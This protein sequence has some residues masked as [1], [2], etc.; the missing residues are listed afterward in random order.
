MEN[1]K[2]TNRE[3]DKVSLQKGKKYMWKYIQ[4]KAKVGEE[5]RGAASYL[6]RLKSLFMFANKFAFGSALAAIIILAL[7][8]TTNFQGLVINKPQTV[9]ASFEMSA[10]DQDASGVSNDSSFTLKST[11]DYSEEVIA[12]NLKV[13]PEVEVKIEKT[14]SGEYEIKP[15]NPLKENGVYHFTITSKQ[16]DPKT[17]ET[18][19]VEFSWTYQVQDNFKITGTL[20]G[21][22]STGVPLETGIEFYFSHENFDFDDAKKHLEISPNVKGEFHKNNKT[23]VFVPKDPLNEATIYNV[24]LKKG[25]KLLDSDKVLTEDLSFAFETIKSGET[26]RSGLQFAQ[27]DYEIGTDSAVAMQAYVYDLESQGID[28]VD[29]EIFKYS[30]QEDF[31]K[32]LQKRLEIPGWCYYSKEFFVHDTSKLKSLGTFKATVEETNY[33]GYIYL[34]DLNLESGYYLFQAKSKDLKVPPDQALV[35]VTDVSAYINISSTDSLIWVNDVKTDQPIENAKVEIAGLKGDY[36]TNKEGILTFKTP[37]NWKNKFDDRNSSFIKIN[38]NDGRAL[39]T[40]V[41]PY[42]DDYMAKYNYWMSFSTD[43][44][45]YK[46]TDKIKFFGFIK[47]KTGKDEFKDLKIKMEYGYQNYVDEISVDPK[48]DGTFIGEIALKNYKPGYYNLTMTNGDDLITSS[49][50]EIADY[51]KPAYNLTIESDKKAVFA[52]ENVKLKVTSKFFDG[53]ALPNLKINYRTSDKEEVLYTDKSGEINLNEKAQGN[54]CNFDNIDEYYCYDINNRYFEV[55]SV[56]GEE[57]DIWDSVDIRIFNSRLTLTGNSEVDEGF[58]K[59]K[60]M[61]N[62][63]DL[64][65]LNSGEDANYYDFIGEVAKGKTISGKI[66]ES[67]WIKTESGQY[68]D[69]INK[70]TQKT[71][72]YTEQKKVI[73]EFK[74]TTDSKGEASYKF[75]VKVDRSYRVLLEAADEKGNMAHEVT[76]FYGSESRSSDYNYY[77]MKILNDK[78]KSGSS[79]FEFGDKVETAFANND[80]VLSS[81]KNGKFLFMQLSNGLKEYSVSNSPNYNFEFKKE[82]VPN[83]NISGVWFNGNSYEVAYG[84][85]A[86]YKNELER[87]KVEIK[88]D[89]ESYEPGEKVT[90]EVKVEDQNGSPSKA[91]VN[92]NLVDEAYY[93][94][95]YDNFADPLDEIYADN[96][97]GVLSQY[98][99]HQNPISGTSDGGK[100]GCFTADTKILMADGSYKAIKDIKIGDMILTKSHAYSLELVPAEVTNTISHEVSEYLVINEDLEV[101]AEH[102]VFVN[103]KWDLAGNVKIGDSLQNKDGVEIKVSSIRQVFEP[104]TVYNFEVKEKHTYFANN[105]YVHNDKGGDGVRN[106]F[107]DTAYFDVVEVGPSGFGEVSFKLPDNITSWRVTSKAIDGADL[108]AGYGTGSI[109]VSLD[110]FADIV[111]NNEYSV[112]DKP[113]LKMRTFGESLK[114]DA[115]VEFNVSA[116]SLG[117]EKGETVYAKGFENAYFALPKLAL[118]A[119]EVVVKVSASGKEDALSKIITVKGSRLNKDHVELIRKVDEKTIFELAEDG[120]T[121]IRFMDGGSAY[122]Y[123]NLLNLYYTDGDRLDQRLSQIVAAEL[124]K[125]HFGED[126]FTYFEDIV[127]NYQPGGLKLLPYGEADIKLTAMVLAVENNPAR[128]DQVSLKQYLYDVYQNKESNLDEIVLSLLGLASLDEPILLSLRKI[129]DEPKLTVE[130]KLY[131]A[132][133]FNNL[134][135]KAEAKKIYKEV[136]DKLAT[137]EGSVYATAVGAVVASGVGEIEQADLLWEFVQLTGFNNE[138]SNLYEIGYT[139]NALAHSNPEKLKFKVKVNEHSEDVELDKWETYG[140]MAYT[141]DLVATSV[142]AGDLAAVVY[143]SETV[144]P[145][146]FE[147]DDRLTIKRYY[148]VDG[149]LVESFKEGDLVEVLLTPSFSGKIK[150]PFFE[151]TDVLP[152][153]FV[154]VTAPRAYSYY[155]YQLHYPY[156]TNGQEVKFYWSP[157]N[158]E[159]G[160][161]SPSIKYYARVV[162]PGEYYA[163]PAKIQ[164]YYDET[165]VNI[166]EANTVN[167]ERL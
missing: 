166:S 141:G 74:L 89:K 122:Y 161:V 111:M 73:D 14:A 10:E 49:Y 124:L 116:K 157:Q 132:L 61:A 21:D 115:K 8:I 135:S 118:G 95:I 9:F 62:E 1:K 84:A 123:S 43:R 53:T 67:E 65:Q 68:Y 33:L 24:K 130:E 51:T 3:V 120:A 19:D 83:V 125:K 144:E 27:T 133:A 64:T 56:L 17:G 77:Q 103:G 37:D 54:S 34:P 164:S 151:V 101:T 92:L 12:A 69:Y 7:V 41:E 50:F 153:G 129:Q 87:L 156:N 112:K 78:D 113:E 143:S 5:K 36:K 82:H 128:Y 20:P 70:K 88:T 150:N 121:E 86:K 99:S 146:E 152:S 105:F 66:V 142:S 126:K 127:S 106:D 148:L 97:S 147:V 160:P 39:I 71:Y 137:D 134:G 91:T 72:N 136:F 47:S 44:P 158:T 93:K 109:K 55:N 60:V 46:P 30:T 31:M 4:Q 6:E 159:F 22:K 58:G 25:L 108:R 138:L 28:G 79:L 114:D 107:E 52:G 85:S 154:P 2:F 90:L 163:D 45:I 23:L 145:S 119:H 140:V 76:Y 15:I 80:A 75:P 165:I 98:D 29:I 16:K 149:K 42:M 110:L 94:M 32:S 26:Y 13:T 162:A 35:Q 40:Q 96:S 102:V 139:K 59:L 117:L 57:T 63:V 131:V 100:G 38:S 48:K 104:V 18:K 81:E 155:D 167:I 11:A